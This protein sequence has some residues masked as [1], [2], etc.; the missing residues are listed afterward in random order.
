MYICKYK[1]N[2]LHDHKPHFSHGLIFIYITYFKT[3]LCKQTYFWWAGG[4][5]N[6]QKNWD[7]YT[8]CKAQ[9]SSLHG[10]LSLYPLYRSSS[11]PP[12]GF[13]GRGNMRTELWIAPQRKK[14]FAGRLGTGPLASFP[15]LA[16]RLHCP[17]DWC[18]LQPGPW[19]TSSAKCWFCLCCRRP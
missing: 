10:E 12:S 6:P 11:T 8:E 13:M 5:E 15:S 17:K 3:L 9:Q 7:F 19:V 1:A 14:R 18:V 16:W 2:Y 4:H